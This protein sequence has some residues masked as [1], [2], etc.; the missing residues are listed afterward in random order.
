[1]KTKAI[2]KTRICEIDEVLNLN[3]VT[4]S[5]LFSAPEPN[6][7][8]IN[9]NLIFNF[10]SIDNHLS[11][12]F[13]K[14]NFINYSLILK[15]DYDILLEVSTNTF[16]FSKGFRNYVLISEDCL[17]ELDNE[18]ILTIRI[19]NSANLLALYYYEDYFI[20]VKELNFTITEDDYDPEFSI[21]TFDDSLYTI[22][23]QIRHG[24]PII[25]TVPSS[26]TS[27]SSTADIDTYNLGFGKDTRTIYFRIICNKIL[28][29]TLS[30][31]DLSSF[32]L[33]IYLPNGLDTVRPALYVP[34]YFVHKVVDQN[35][36]IYRASFE[37]NKQGI[38]NG[39]EYVDGYMYFDVH[40]PL[41][42]QKTLGFEFDFSIP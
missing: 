37:F 4:A 34:M 41:T 23:R 7:L 13:I 18:G 42:I 24:I 10:N 2:N 32:K 28:E 17:F 39:V 30:V 38:Y 11:I 9:D 40:V 16:I 35:I 29:N 12:E 15:I 5:G 22:P 14:N 25:S 20:S 27:A 26:I 6:Q 8:K 31:N 36:S 21:G 33:K 3:F 19:P 1:M